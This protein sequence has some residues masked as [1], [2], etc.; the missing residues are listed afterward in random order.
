M[1]F[2]RKKQRHPPFVSGKKCSL[3]DLINEKDTNDL[4]TRHQISSCIILFRKEITTKKSIEL[5]KFLKRHG[6]LSKAKTVLCT[7]RNNRYRYF[8]RLVENN[9]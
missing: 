4:Q 3:T 7:K 6:I 9:N 8:E 5:M 1:N 2:V